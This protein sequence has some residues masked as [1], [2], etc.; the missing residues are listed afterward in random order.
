MKDSFIGKQEI[1]EFLNTLDNN[2]DSSIF[3]Y[4]SDNKKS[5]DKSNNSEILE[6]HSLIGETPYRYYN[7]K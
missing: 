3:K 2:K 1:N 6:C 7:L 4:G 5:T